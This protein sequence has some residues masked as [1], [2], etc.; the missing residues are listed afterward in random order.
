[1]NRMFWIF[2]QAVAAI[3]VVIGITYSIVRAYEY[4]GEIDPA[5]FFTYQV[6]DVEQIGGNKAILYVKNE[7]ATPRCAMNLVMATQNGVMILSY[8]YLDLEGN[9]RVYA[10]LKGRYVPMPMDA[11]VEQD[12]RDKLYQL[13]GITDVEKEK[14]ADNA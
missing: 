8:A 6:V 5:Q 12:F 10:L 1:M 13:N 11:D 9:L 4:E 7:K 2:I 3:A 14:K